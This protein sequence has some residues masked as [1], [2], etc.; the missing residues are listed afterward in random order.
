MGTTF[1]HFNRGL[2]CS[3]HVNRALGTRSLLVWIVSLCDQLAFFSVDWGSDSS[4]SGL[5]LVC[6][7][8]HPSVGEPEQPMLTP[9][10]VSSVV[11]APWSMRWLD[12]IGRESWDWRVPLA[13][14][15]PSSPP[16]GGRSSSPKCVP[17]A[18][19][20]LAS[21]QCKS[22]LLLSSSLLLLLDH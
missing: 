2:G 17:T 11:G 20:N 13:L 21:A 1:A 5:A 12:G 18:G 15:S 8:R 7:N 6:G 10:I 19:P 9:E 3:G 16:K 22:L 4:E 14:A